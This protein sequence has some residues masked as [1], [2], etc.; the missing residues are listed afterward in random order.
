MR[1]R[2]HR[3]PPPIANVTMAMC[4]ALSGPHELLSGMGM[5]GSFR[6]RKHGRDRDRELSFDRKKLFV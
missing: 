2:I 3:H 5:I 1:E 4:S 6:A